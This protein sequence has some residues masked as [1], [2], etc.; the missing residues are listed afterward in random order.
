MNPQRL[1]SGGICGSIGTL[2]VVY[3]I[4]KVMCGCTIYILAKRLRFECAE[5]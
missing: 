4:G 3:R 1:R 5:L 2:V